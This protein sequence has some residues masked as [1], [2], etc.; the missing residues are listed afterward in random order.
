M[1]VIDCFPYFNEKELLELRINLLNDHVDKFIITD[2]NYTHSGI[3]KPF[4][5]KNTL[6]E[7]GLLSDKIQVIE[8]ELPSYNEEKCAWVR[9]RMQ[10]NVA[11]EY[12]EDDDVCIISD[13]DE[14]INPNFIEYYTLVA[15]SYPE[16]I[17]RIP[18]A[19]LMNRGDLR[20]Y[21]ENENPIS[22]STPFIC[23][24]QH[25]KKYT[26]S[27][28]RESH[29]LSS[30]HLD[31]SDIFI[32]EDNIIK[33]AGW[34]FSWM[35]DNNRLKTK[36]ESFLHWDEVSV[37][38]NYIPKENEPD[39]L[40]RQNHILKKYPTELLPQ[41][42]FD[43]D[44]V[45]N[46]LQLKKQISVIQVGTNR[47]NDDL[48]R[49]L[50]SN[51]NDLNFGLFIE[52][53]AIFN[54]QIKKCYEK[55]SNIF[56]ENIAIIPENY[57]DK[58]EIEIFYHTGD[59]TLETTSCIKDHLIK[60]EQYYS[61]GEIK[62]FKVSCMTLTKLFEKYS[63]KNLDWLLLD[64]EGIDAEVILTFNWQ[65]YNIKRVEFEYIHLGTYTETIER[66]FYNMGYKK[67]N[68]LHQ[69]DWAFEKQ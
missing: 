36:E 4:T 1:R 19:F 40:G 51:C 52:P 28:I 47:S 33:D 6:K 25:L 16:N 63:I 44:R 59:P 48:S 26:L 8:I 17:L 42:I 56:I 11:S 34:H 67:V 60:H 23:L 50:L 27:D 55:F 7:L 3:S 5:C 38:S 65:N 46:F 35:G 39:C 53:N 45:R 14:I 9:E 24:K 2:A 37:Q 12:I 43:L 57:T 21:D 64:I 54:D 32:T 66:K 49:Y 31:Y 68:S 10:R 62:S 30:H 61:N 18:L 29:A 20:V 41:K 22:W 13:C 69:F 58:N 15:K